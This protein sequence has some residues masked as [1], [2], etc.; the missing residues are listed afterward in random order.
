M[1]QHIVP[2]PAEAG[3]PPEEAGEARIHQILDGT[4]AFA[5]RLTA[6][7]RLR[8]VSRNALEAGG[9]ARAEVLGLPFWD[10]PWWSHDPAEQAR[11]RTAID[12][13]RAGR[14]SRYDAVVRIQGDGRLH[15]A[16]Q[17]AP[18]TDRQGR[19]TELLAS[20]F[21]VTDRVRAQRRLEDTVHE[22]GHRI[23]NLLA[24]VRAMATMT[25]R[26]SGPEAAFGDFLARL[27]ALVA[28]HDAL[29]ESV[30]AEGFFGQIVRRLMS[31]YLD[32]PEPRIRVAGPRLRLARDPAK[33]LG[34]CIYELATNAM[35]HGA[36]S[37]PGGRVAIGLSAPGADG[38]VSF[39]W[40]E[41]GGPAALPPGRKGYGT[42]FVT[43]SLQ[44]VF[45]GVVRRDYGPEGLRIAVEGPAPGLFL[46]PGDDEAC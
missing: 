28:A 22:M 5:A 16:F 43:L 1:S 29:N 10:T 41:S 33:M 24:T 35:K 17:L 9:V 31:P 13:A 7:G 39:T 2:A 20:A 21:D 15:I 12:D 44:A 23:K 36:L 45:G 46:P 3:L 4:L 37:E 26:S 30:S 34:L 6:E 32:G 18:L 14:I 19:V 42:D 38:A 40:E 25:R 8:D 11:L 27:D